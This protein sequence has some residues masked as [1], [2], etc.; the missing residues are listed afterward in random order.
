MN[1]LMIG[2]S[3]TF[4]FDVP[5]ILESACRSAGKDVCVDSVTKGGWTLLQHADPNDECGKVLE[6]KLRSGVLYDVVILQEQSSRPFEDYPKFLE[7]CEAL[8]KKL[9]AYN[10]STRVILYE[11]WGYGDDFSYLTGRGWK[12]ETMYEKLRAS[13]ADA[14]KT[15]G[16]EVSHVGEGLL[17]LYRETKID[18]YWTDRKH[19]SYA[20][21]YLSAL[22]H[23][24]RIFPDLQAEQI[25][26]LGEC[27]EETACRIRRI[28]ET[29]R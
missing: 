16:A 27:E 22:T 6:E 4:Y 10:P 13:Y 3:F 20:G 24:L 5:K 29:T 9:R 12:S 15:V 8:T 23:A 7:G 19:Q 14:A 25:R 18:P 11:T 2:N 17:K 26:F 21:S 28:V 1:I